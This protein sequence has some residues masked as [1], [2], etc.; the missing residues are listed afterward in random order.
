MYT[1]QS[2]LLPEEDELDE[3]PEEDPEDELPEED[4]DELP[5][6]P[7]DEAEEDEPALASYPLVSA[8]PTSLHFPSLS[9]AHPFSL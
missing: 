9:Q 7:E 5:E 6:D 8:S 3:L 2:A 1:S 4:P